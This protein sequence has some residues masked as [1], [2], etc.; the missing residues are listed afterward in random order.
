MTN[1]PDNQGATYPHDMSEASHASDGPLHEAT[2]EDLKMIMDNA[3]EY[4][5]QLAALGGVEQPPA[6]SM[7]NKI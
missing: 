6:M 1:T 7:T 3:A 2:L 4:R 5:R